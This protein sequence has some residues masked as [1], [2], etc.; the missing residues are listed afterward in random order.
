MK[1]SKNK[2]YI[3]RQADDG[4]IPS[5][6]RRLI[7]PSCEETLTQADIENFSYCPFCNYRFEIN[8]QLEDFILEPIVERW[9]RQQ[10]MMHGGGI[11]R[12]QQQR[13]PGF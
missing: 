8:L 11:H 13:P 2:R 9:M 10:D 6:D 12:H 1:N 4:R 7:C 5:I 3:F